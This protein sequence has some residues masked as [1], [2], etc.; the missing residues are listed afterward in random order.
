MDAT[1]ETFDLLHS[2]KK[3]AERRELIDNAVINYMD[4]DN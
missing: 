4:L 2:K 1:L 3:A